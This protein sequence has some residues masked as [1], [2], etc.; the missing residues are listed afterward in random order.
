MEADGSIPSWAT[1]I[2]VGVNSMKRKNFSQLPSNKTMQSILDA[3]ED[4]KIPPLHFD[5]HYVHYDAFVDWLTYLDIDV[6]FFSANDEWSLLMDKARQTQQFVIDKTLKGIR[7]ND[8][9]LLQKLYAIENYLGESDNVE[10]ADVILVLGSK[11]LGRADKAVRL[12]KQG[13]GKLLVMSGRSR[14]DS[15]ESESEAKVFAKRALELGVEED[16]ILI[17]DTSVT[18]ASN[19]RH[20]LNLLDRKDIS[21]SSIIILTAWFA[22]RRACGHLMKYTD[23]VQII[24]VN[25]DMDPTWRLAPGNWY[26]NELGLGV[27]F[28]EFLKM[29]MAE[30]INT[31]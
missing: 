8:A 9:V 20:S 27:I 11:D 15:D 2:V 23:D 18:V 31:I 30:S 5:K 28:G 14:M 25:S 6:S 17:E 10:R 22:Q 1:V 12:L 26:K 13:Y 21:Y 19:I 16:R 29:K 3:E 4:R 24:R 7:N